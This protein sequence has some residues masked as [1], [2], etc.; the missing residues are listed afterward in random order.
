[1]F[2]TVVGVKAASKITSSEQKAYAEAAEVANEVILSI[3]TVNAF[4]AQKMELFRYDRQLLTAKNMAIKVGITM[5]ISFGVIYGMIYAMYALSFGFGT[6]LFQE[7]L[8][9]PGG[10]IICFFGI[11]IAAFSI[12]QAGSN[13]ESFV[14]GQAAAH[15]VFKTIDRVS[16]IDPLSEE[17]TKLEGKEVSGEVSLTNV[18]FSYPSRPDLE[19]LKGIDMTIKPG[20]TVAFVGPSGC[21]KST[22]IQ[23]L[24][25]FYDVDSGEIKIDEHDVKNI[26]VKSLRSIIG[27]VKQEPTLFATTIEENIRF[28]KE[29]ATRAEI[30]AALQAANAISFVNKF[31]KG[32]DTQV[33]DKGGHLS[34]GQKQR[35]AIARALISDPKILLLDEA[36][37]ALD[38]ESE[39]I[40]QD[41]LDKASRG[42]TTI[43]IAHRLSTVRNADRIFGIR[44]GEIVEVGSHEELYQKENGL[45][46]ALVDAQLGGEAVEKLNNDKLETNETEKVEL[47]KKVDAEEEEDVTGETEDELPEVTVWEVLEFN[48]PEY[49]LMGFGLIVAMLAGTTEPI[50]AILFADVLGAYA[51]YGNNMTELWKVIWGYI[52]GFLGIALGALVVHTLRSAI[53]FQTG[54]LLIRRVRFL[55]FKAL[56][57]QEIAFYDDPKFPSGVLTSRLATDCSKLAGMTGSR[58]SALFQA[59]GAGILALIVGF[60]YSWELT[61]LCFV[62]VPLMMLA[63]MIEVRQTMVNKDADAD[64]D[65]TDA[66]GSC[67]AIAFEVTN[68]IET[69]A[70]LHKENYFLERFCAANETSKKG[71]RKSALLRGFAHG[72]SQSMMFFSMCAVF[73]LGLFLV[74]EKRITF[75]AVFKVLMAV[76]FGS[77]QMGQAMALAPDYA[78]ALLAARR[79]FFLFNK[80]SKCDPESKTG[81][82]LDKVEGKIEFKN[83]HFTYPHRPDMKVLKGINLTIQPGESLALVGQ[84]GCGKSTLIQ[85]IERFYDPDEGEILLDGVNTKELNLNWLRKNLGF[86]QQEPVLMNRSIADNIRQGQADILG[87]VIEAT[88]E[89]FDKVIHVKAETDE[90]K[91]KTSENMYP[92]D[93]VVECAK[94]AN[95]DDFIQNQAHGYE[96]NVGRGGGSLSGGQ[97]QR[98]AIA[99]TLMMK[100]SILL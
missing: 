23:L 59:V 61:L 66:K 16:K 6:W 10:L 24:Q 9:T 22:I 86:V 18:K 62:F 75:D 85:L 87:D 14:Q 79:V 19:V 15:H 67:S 49:I 54:A 77:M 41:A 92:I 13:F 5:G 98:V 34:G 11:I 68:N 39:K 51:M 73:R 27:I 8:I 17:G 69:V 30:E 81:R 36:T 33:G 43:I 4:C 94:S 52:G 45:Y 64:A 35:I 55:Y 89:H 46:K 47:N 12:S 1:M 21:G 71:N 44:N 58:I 56:M 50:N 97:K 57:R 88:Y 63:G 70:S 91:G 25:R 20:E 65:K 28:G 90:F 93:Q 40:V 84:S 100:P 83:V 7:S 38:A 29:D 82:T 32:L 72:Y 42:R 31:D 80:K 37:S 53:F 26:N 3:R 2:V 78:E 95:I 74:D 60:I 48:K 99:R 76:M 96:T